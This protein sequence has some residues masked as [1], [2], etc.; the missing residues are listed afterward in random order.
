MQEFGEEAQEK[1]RTVR[2]GIALALLG[3]LRNPLNN[4]YVRFDPHDE[5]E[6]MRPHIKDAAHI[7]YRAYEQDRG[8]LVHRIYEL[9][10]QGPD[11]TKDEEAELAGHMNSL[12]SRV[13]SPA[14]ITPS[15]EQEKIMAA[16]LEKVG[17]TR[18]I[19]LKWGLGVTTLGL[20]T[21]ANYQASKAKEEW[22]KEERH[23]GKIAAHAGY[24][25]LA[26]VSAAV[27]GFITIAIHYDEQQASEARDEQ[28][29]QRYRDSGD[30][31]EARVVD[32]MVYA[33]A[34]QIK[35]AP[36]LGL[37]FNDIRKDRGARS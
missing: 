26:G 8:A 30:M 17:S 12:I 37:Q 24:A 28:I 14:E 19:F 11:I 7:L 33:L 9:M 4:H 2:R 35:R 27:A 5:R 15:V 25:M 32:R 20:G 1:L 29:E 16:D 22:N 3:N 10:A 36:E 31:L 23:F 6:Q 13:V 21:G 18:R 34:Q